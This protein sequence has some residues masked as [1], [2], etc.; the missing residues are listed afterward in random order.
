MQE[1]VFPKLYALASTG[2][3]K[4]WEISVH[5]Q[6][7]GTCNI[8]RSHGFTG[9]KMQV[10]FKPV[11]SG[12]N[13]G[14][15]NETTVFQQAVS[16]ALS[17][18][19][20]KKD[21]AYTEGKPEKEDPVPL[22]MLA[23][24][25][26]KRK[27]N[28]EY[29]CYA[30]P[31]LNGVRVFARKVDVNTIEYTSRNGKKYDT[32]GHITPNL[33][34][35]M[36]VGEIVDGEVY[37]H[38]MGFQQII[39]LVKKQRYESEGLCFWGY[40]KADPDAEYEARLHWLN[41]VIHGYPA[42]GEPIVLVPTYIADCEEDIYKYHSKFVK[43]GFEGVIIRNQT[44]KYKFR[45]RSKDLQ[46]YKEFFDEEFKIIAGKEAEG[47]HSGCVVFVCD[48]GNG[49]YVDVVPK[50]TLKKRREMLKDL[51]SY[52]GKELTVRYQ[53]KSEDGVPI[54]PVGL[55]VRDYE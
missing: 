23:H 49:N 11:K 45:H 32:L 9:H 3:Q 22:P 35:M 42:I 14:R 38:G 51:D 1:K 53:E 31:K 19:N 2:K 10:T 5:E 21:R 55:V 13:L 36:S 20:K 25:F 41:K 33:L 39:R 50:T 40:D 8:R 52:I 46:K 15:S 48:V 12:K 18:W 43:Q 4:E 29:P 26:D 44:G 16:D 24:S 54:F 17:L 37:V 34:E 47:T 30:Q 7:D 6:E 27:H 28:I